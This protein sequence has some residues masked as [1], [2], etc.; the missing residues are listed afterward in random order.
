MHAGCSNFLRLLPCPWGSALGQEASWPLSTSRPAP[1]SGT[2]M[3]YCSKMRSCRKMSSLIFR[4]WNSSSICTWASS[5][6]CRTDSMW[7]IELPWGV[8]LLDTA[9]SLWQ[10]GE[11]KGGRGLSMLKVTEKEG[12]LPHLSKVDVNQLSHSINRHLSNSCCEPDAI[13]LMSEPKLY[14]SCFGFTSLFPRLVVLLFLKQTC[15]RNK[16]KLCMRKNSKRHKILEKWN[17]S[18][19]ICSLICIVLT[20][21]YT[22]I[23]L[24]QYIQTNILKAYFLK[25]FLLLLHRLFVKTDDV[26]VAKIVSMHFIKLC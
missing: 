26:M 1:P 22:H 7:L 8:L 6:C 24:S 20:H 19:L 18:T 4:S 16:I 15:E 5:S 2:S 17:G 11:K 14:E 25:I 13:C 9:E 12:D 23:H 3:V 21:T 10:S